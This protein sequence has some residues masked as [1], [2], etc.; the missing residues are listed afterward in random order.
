MDGD[1]NGS[2]IHDRGAFE[3]RPQQLE[4]ETLTMVAK[5]SDTHST[6]TD[7]C[8]APTLSCLYSGGSGTNLQA[9][10][11]NDFVTYRTATLPT[12]T[13]AVSVRFKKAPN[14][15]RFRLAFANS[16]SGTYTNIGSEQNGYSVVT[17]WVTVNLGNVTITSSGQKYF[18][19]TVT[20]K[21]GAS[22]G[23]QLFPDTI[24]LVK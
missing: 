18:R 17:D 8:A 3:N 23:Y 22:S 14:A 1:G 5:S 6:A 21:S 4:T 11:T 12:G 7:G 24:D 16:Q 20:G 2:K 10:A 9:N 19:F 13:Y 15:G